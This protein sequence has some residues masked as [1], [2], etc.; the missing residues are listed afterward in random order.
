MGGLSIPLRDSARDQMLER[1]LDLMT[2]QRQ[3][4]EATVLVT[5]QNTQETGDVM[6]TPRATQEVSKKSQDYEGWKEAATEPLETYWNLLDLEEEV[7]TTILYSKRS[8][9][10][11]NLQADFQQPSSSLPDFQEQFGLIDL[12]STQ[13]LIK[14]DESQGDHGTTNSAL[15]DLEELVSDA[16][17]LPSPQEFQE[18]NGIQEV[19]FY[20]DTEGSVESEA[21]LE[22]DDQLWGFS[23]LEV[24]CAP[25]R[26]LPYFSALPGKVRRQIWQFARPDARY[27]KIRESK[28]SA[29]LY[30]DA[31]IP[32]LLRT[33]QE[34]RK[35]ALTWYDLSF[36]R[37]PEMGFWD[38]NTLNKLM[39]KALTEGERAQ[40]RIFFDW[41]R[42]GIYS[43]CARCNGHRMS[44]R[45]APLSFDWLRVKRLAYEGPLSINP[46]YKLTLCYP[47]VESIMLIR[48]RSAVRRTAVSPSEFIPVDEKFEWEGDDLL[49][50]C[51]ETI[52]NTDLEC[53]ALDTI[54]SVQRMTLMDVNQ[55]GVVDRTESSYWPCR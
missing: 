28:W 32:A 25:P 48:G 42:D 18:T 43:Q 14:P 11:E 36:A 52:Q 9:E 53:D 29:A 35:V 2:E 31:Q 6:K 44:C 8:H 15:F 12:S 40:P 34:S 30:S 3:K 4:Q 13:R 22:D 41:E 47:A 5:S 46:F 27:I 33:C 16:T 50:T 39:D 45:H 49:A 17:A 19:E 54:T 37:D 51:L 20:Q 24:D 21:H 23:D 7:G 55:T 26:I 38:Q 10:T 1:Y